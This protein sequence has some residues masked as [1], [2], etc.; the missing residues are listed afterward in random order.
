[1]GFV[2]V[3]EAEQ[4]FALRGQTTTLL[5]VLRCNDFR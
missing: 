3:H 5:F 1:V 4:Q 2:V